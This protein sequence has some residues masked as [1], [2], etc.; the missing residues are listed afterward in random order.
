MAVNWEDLIPE[1]EANV[2]TPTAIASRSTRDRISEILGI[3]VPDYSPVEQN[4][5]TPVSRMPQ[6][7]DYTYTPKPKNLKLVASLMFLY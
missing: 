1:L 4:L 5:P 2:N 6:V 3:E 7:I